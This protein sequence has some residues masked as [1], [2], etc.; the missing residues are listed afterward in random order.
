MIE[1]CA[2]T[3]PNQDISASKPCRCADRKSHPLKIDGAMISFRPVIM[4]H[5]AVL[6]N[7]KLDQ[8]FAKKPALSITSCY[9][10]LL[11]QC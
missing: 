5:E 1:W 6:A 11:S 3:K 10:R 7:P 9:Y 4:T 8:S 2:L